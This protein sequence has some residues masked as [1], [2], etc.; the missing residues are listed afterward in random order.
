MG[1][2]IYTAA[3]VLVRADLSVQ[4]AADL[5]NLYPEDIAWAIEE[6]GRCDTDE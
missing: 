4:E 1:Y 5:M 3:R 6:Y 2:D